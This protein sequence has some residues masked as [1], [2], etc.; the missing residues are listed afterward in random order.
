LV[1]KPA[2]EIEEDGDSGT[3]IAANNMT[4]VYYVQNELGLVQQKC[5]CGEL[6][7]L[8]IIVYR[9]TGKGIKVGII[10]TGN[11]FNTFSCAHTEVVFTNTFV[12]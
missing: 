3:L 7:L 1:S 9:L 5:C 4:G 6:S 10:D 11:A 2:V 8:N 12:L